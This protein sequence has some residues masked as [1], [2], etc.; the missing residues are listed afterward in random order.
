MSQRDDEEVSQLIGC[1]E[2]ASQ[3]ICSKFPCSVSSQE[4]D[5]GKTVPG[6]MLEVYKHKKQNRTE[7]EILEVPC[8]SNERDVLQLLDVV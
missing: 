1:K 8:V 2:C 5:E 4:V 3:E 7:S 6:T